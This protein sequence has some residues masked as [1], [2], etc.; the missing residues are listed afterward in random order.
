MAFVA[1]GAVVLAV[2]L[3]ALAWSHAATSG[4]KLVLQATPDMPSMPRL[5]DG[6]KLPDAPVPAPK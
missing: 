1:G 3:L 6:P 4:L 2:V 5:P